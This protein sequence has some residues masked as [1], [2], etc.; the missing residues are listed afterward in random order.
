MT[1]FSFLLLLCI[2]VHIGIFVSAD[3]LDEDIGTMS[4]YR[5]PSPT[6]QE[7][8][9]EDET[10]MEVDLLVPQKIKLGRT[11]TLVSTGSLSLVSFF[12]FWVCRRKRGCDYDDDG[13]AG[14]RSEMDGITQPDHFQLGIASPL[15]DSE[16]EKWIDMVIG[17]SDDDD[18]DD[19]DDDGDEDVKPH[20]HDTVDV[21]EEYSIDAHQNRKRTRSIGPSS[22]TNRRRSLRNHSRKA[23]GRRKMER[24]GDSFVL[25]LEKI[26]EETGDF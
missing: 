19:G 12:A 2:A 5:F 18:D 11:A 22:G 7:H 8:F 24:T 1:S 6:P 26:D 21:S 15:S 4:N 17:L 14:P 13:F 20:H 25:G 23:S 3:E 9:S 10:D 16:N